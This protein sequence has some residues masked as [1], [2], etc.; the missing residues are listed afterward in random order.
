[1]PTS[2]E[3]WIEYYPFLESLD[4]IQ[5]LKLPTFLVVYEILLRV[6]YSLGSP[7]IWSHDYVL[8]VA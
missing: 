1:M 3:K 4:W 2:V 7:F 8:V 6:F 5:R